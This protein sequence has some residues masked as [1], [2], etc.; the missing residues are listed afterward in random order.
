MLL[1]VDHEASSV[2]EDEVAVVV[3]D[4][5]EDQAVVDQAEVARTGK[6]ERNGCQ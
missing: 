4:E 6:T 5:A 3:V 1:V 2:Q